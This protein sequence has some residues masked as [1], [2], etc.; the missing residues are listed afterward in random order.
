MPNDETVSDSLLEKFNNISTN[1][2]INDRIIKKI[3]IIKENVAEK[4]FRTNQQLLPKNNNHNNNNNENMNSSSITMINNSKWIKENLLSPIAT[5]TTTKSAAGTKM[6]PSLATK[7]NNMLNKLYLS[8][9]QESIFTQNTNKLT[10]KCSSAIN[11]N[12][13]SLDEQQQQQHENKICIED[14]Y[15][16]G[17]S[18]VQGSDQHVYVKDLVN[19]GPGERSGIQIGDQVHKTT[20]CISFYFLFFFLLCVGEY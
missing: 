2:P 17:I 7:P 3:T 6:M 18:I 16:L 4:N 13:N 10:V 19:N 5:T 1:Q 11:Q 15:T 9:S 8:R 14:G 20:L 12:N